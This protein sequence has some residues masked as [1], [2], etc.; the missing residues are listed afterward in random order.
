MGLENIIKEQQ[1]GKE[2]TPEWMIGE[3]LLE[4][5]RRSPLAAELLERDLTVPEMDLT[6]AAGQMK[7]YADEKKKT[8]KGNCVCVT[9]LEAE[10]VLRK[11][12]H[13]PEDEPDQKPAE[14]AGVIVNLADF[15]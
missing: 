12:Y 13:L 3:Q 15:L 10:Q 2:N 8:I 7:K 1:A 14:G 11:F 5:A 4:M 9:P 6:A